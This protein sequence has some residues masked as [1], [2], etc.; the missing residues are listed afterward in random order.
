MLTRKSPIFRKWVNL[1]FFYWVRL[2]WRFVCSQRICIR[3]DLRI[4]LLAFVPFPSQMLLIFIR[5]QNIFIQWLQ[6]V[7]SF[8]VWRRNV[9]NFRIVLKQKL[10]LFYR[11]FF[12]LFINNLKTSKT[13]KGIEIILFLFF[14]LFNNTFE[15][16]IGIIK[17]DLIQ[18]IFHLMLCDFFYTSLNLYLFQCLLTSEFNFNILV[19][20]AINGK[21]S[22]GVNHRRMMS[23]LNL[24]I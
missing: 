2:I 24:C 14:N 8:C 12:R 4:H 9:E 22:S 15:I 20:H 13:F 23:I 7:F 11:L 19:V 18:L 16:L 17:T 3:L 5:L 6:L 10:Y 21:S 1:C